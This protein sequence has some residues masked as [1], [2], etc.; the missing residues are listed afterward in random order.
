M[1]LVTKCPICKTPVERS[2]PE[3]PF[4]TDRCRLLDL[5]NWAAERY[6]IS[7]PAF[8]DEIDEEFDAGRD[9]ARDEIGNEDEPS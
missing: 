2:N 9:R 4:C 7:S 5:G 1:P 3:F 6:V 8:L